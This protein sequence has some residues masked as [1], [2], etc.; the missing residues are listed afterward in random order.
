MALRFIYIKYFSRF[1]CKRR[2]DLHQTFCDILMYRRLANPKLLRRLPDGGIVFDNIISNINCS[3]LNIILQKKSPQ[4]TFLHC[5]KCSGG[6]WQFPSF[7][8]IN[9]HLLHLY[10]TPGAKLKPFFTSPASETPPA[11]YSNNH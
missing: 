2:I 9:L 6:L 1:L 10:R 11:P 4:N 3:F 5:M 7:E 8:L